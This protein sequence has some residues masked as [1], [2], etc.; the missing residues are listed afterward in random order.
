MSVQDR[1][2]A[3]IHESE[4]VLLIRHGLQPVETFHQE[5]GGGPAPSLH[6]DDPRDF[7]ASLLAVGSEIMRRQSG[8]RYKEHLGGTVCDQPSGVLRRP[9]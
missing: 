6:Q 4:A 3:Q 1:R 8:G 9:R 5:A 7:P 2:C